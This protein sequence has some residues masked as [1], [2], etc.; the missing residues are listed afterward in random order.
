MKQPKPAASGGAKR[1][2]GLRLYRPEDLTPSS[3]A[4]PNG[5]VARWLI[6]GYPATLQ[7]WT[8]A[9]WASLSDPPPDAQRLDNG[10]W[11]SLR[12]E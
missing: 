4:E 12:I 9:E 2:P 11:C 5:G 6:N 1:R 7:I 10:V 3:G 8:D